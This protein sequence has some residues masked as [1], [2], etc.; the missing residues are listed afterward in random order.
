MSVSRGGDGRLDYA[1]LDVQHIAH[2][3]NNSTS[4]SGL[5]FD[6][7]DNREFAV[8]DEFGLD[9]DE[10][11][12]LV[13]LRTS[14]IAGPT[15]NVS[16]ETEPG[17]VNWEGGL[18]V[19]MA[20]EEFSTTGNAFAN[21]IVPPEDGSVTL[22]VAWG[23]DENPAQL[24]IWHLISQAGFNDT[25]NGTGGGGIA[26]NRET[27]VDFRGGLVEGHG[28]V[29]DANDDL[30]SYIEMD[31][32]TITHHHKCLVHYTLYYNTMTVEGARQAFGVP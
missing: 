32:D 14:I 7:T 18:G 25:P 31:T 15:A 29:L 3:V 6:V 21:D 13:A 10:L 16:S 2:K 23:Q 28:P 24:D 12:E 30:N 19:N 22:G 4:G 1:D 20:T 27:N 11:A 9:N 26:M 8:Q 5:S 17:Y